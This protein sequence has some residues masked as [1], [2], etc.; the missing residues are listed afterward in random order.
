[1]KGLFHGCCFSECF[2]DDV[3]SEEL[4]EHNRGLAWVGWVDDVGW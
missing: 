3:W 2:D 1:M 4:W